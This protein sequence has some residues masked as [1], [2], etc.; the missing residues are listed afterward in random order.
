MNEIATTHP[1]GALALSD[2]QLISVLES[3]VFPGAKRES[4]ALVIG[5]CKAAGLD[6][7]QKPVHI[8][9]MSVKVA[10]AKDANNSR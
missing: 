4:I 6:P 5:Y 9:P 1:G 7:L 8:V 10:G 3:S 2:D